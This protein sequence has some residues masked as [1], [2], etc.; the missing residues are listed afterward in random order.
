MPYSVKVAPLR[1]RL[2][3]TRGMG[4]GLIVLLLGVRLAAQSD[5]LQFGFDSRHTGVNPFETH[6][7]PANV[8]TLRVLFKVR[9]PAVADGAPAYLSGIST[10]A[11]TRDLLFLTTKDGRLLALDAL[12]GETLWSHQPASGPNYTTSS[13]AVDPNRQ[14]VYSY[15]LEGQVHKYAVGDGSEVTGNGWPELATLKPDVEKGSSALSF[16]TLSDQST[17]LYVANGGYPGDDG[18]YQGHLT[19]IALA[20]GAQTVFNTDCSQIA[21]HLTAGGSPNCGSVQSAVWSR[22]G[23]VYDAELGRIF[24]ATGNGVFDANQGGHNWGDSVIALRPDASSDNGAPLDSYTPTDFQ[25][26]ADNDLDLGSTSPVLLPSPSGGT[27]PHLA[28][29]VGKDGQLRLLNLDN[30]SSQGGPGHAGGELQEPG[31]APGGWGASTARGVDESSR[32]HELG[33]RG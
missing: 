29:Q 31:G 15:S 12:S 21:A 16:A 33:V 5:W 32:R 20:S 25:S 8:G 14:F 28:L 18:Q 4:A 7:S 26:L 13:P 22:P 2:L 11:G 23:V 1:H 17:N 6:L 30:L 10:A 9:L 19:A 3:L 27:F 24:I